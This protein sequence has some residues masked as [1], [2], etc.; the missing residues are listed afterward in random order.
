MA[1]LVAAMVFAL[2]G[3]VFAIALVVRLAKKKP[4]KRALLA[5]ATLAGFVLAGG[6]AHM[7]TAVFGPDV[8]AEFNKEFEGEMGSDTGGDSMDFEGDL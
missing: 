4:G 1:S 6:A 3:A 7:S 5:V 8:G 2:A